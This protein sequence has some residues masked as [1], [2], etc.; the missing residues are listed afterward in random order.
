[1]WWGVLN[2]LEES[3]G[4]EYKFDQISSKSPFPKPDVRKVTI[5]DNPVKK[6]DSNKAADEGVCLGIHVAEGDEA[7]WDGSLRVEIEVILGDELEDIIVIEEIV[8]HGTFGGGYLFEFVFFVLP[9][10]FPFLVVGY[11][12]RIDHHNY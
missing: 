7:E 3:E 1:M 2:R 12:L 5:E 10:E 9:P 6:E 8:E 11:R 4:P